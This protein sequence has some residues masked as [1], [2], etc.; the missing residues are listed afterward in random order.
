M[1][2]RSDTDNSPRSFLRRAILNAS[3]GNRKQIFTFN[4]FCVQFI[5]Q[6]KGA[7]KIY[8]TDGK[9]H[10]LLNLFSNHLELLQS[11]PLA[12]GLASHSILATS[13]M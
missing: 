2:S 7:G 8:V 11:I 3:V 13:S 10:T 5:A 9:F 6:S 4:F 12:T 1:R